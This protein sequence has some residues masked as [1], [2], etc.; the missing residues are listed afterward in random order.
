MRH[1]MITALTVTVLT[2]C[3]H[4]QANTY[5]QIWSQ[6]ELDAQLEVTNKQCAE[7]LRSDKRLDPIRSYLPLGTGEKPTIQQLAS[8]KK[9]TPKEK[10]SILLL[11]LIVTQCIDDRIAILSNPQSGISKQIVNINKSW[12]QS[13]TKAKANLWAGKTT[14]GEYLVSYQEINAS[15]IKEAEAT[16]A[17]EQTQYQNAKYQ[18][19]QLAIQQQQATAQTLMLFNQAAKTYRG[20]VQTNCVRIGGQTSCTSY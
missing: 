6:N 14:Y 15:V 11:D 7:T 19:A 5:S 13:L 9:P 16:H 2:G 3:A 8:K 17:N 18:Q 4:H 20:P 12:A 1:F 10:E